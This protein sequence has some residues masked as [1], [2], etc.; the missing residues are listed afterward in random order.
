MVAKSTSQSDD[1]IEAMERYVDGDPSG[2][3]QVYAAMA[4]VVGRCLRRW[5]GDPGRADDLVQ[6]TF[7]RV[8]R[9]R[10]RYRRGAPVGPWILTI[11]RRLS[12]DTL[13][14]RGRSKEH[15]TRDGAIPEKLMGLHDDTEPD[16]EEMIAAV[17]AAV[18]DLPRTLREVVAMHKLDGRPLADVAAAL[19]IKEGTARVRAHRGYR[20]LKQMLTKR[21]RGGKEAG[22]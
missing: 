21:L 8:H 7:I 3:R 11:A 10:Q 6:E 12:I 2:F 22:S 18:H 4:P 13:R 1:L 5:I 14:K 15:L 9:A 17:R 16:V 19:E 20:R